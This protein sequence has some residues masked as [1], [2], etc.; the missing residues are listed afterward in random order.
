M[1]VGHG[2]LEKSWTCSSFICVYGTRHDDHRDSMVGVLELGGRL[3]RHRN[4]SSS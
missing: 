3:E 4:C 1:N 2:D